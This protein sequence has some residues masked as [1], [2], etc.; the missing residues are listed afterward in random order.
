M[1]LTK[2]SVPTPS[3][4]VAPADYTAILAQLEAKNQA[5]TGRNPVDLDAE[6]IPEGTIILVGGVLYKAEAAEPITGTPSLYVKITPSGATASCAY[7]AN[8]S[9]VAWDAAEGG[10][11]DGSGN[12]HLFDEGLAVGTGVVG[13][14][15]TLLGQLH[16]SAM[17]GTLANARLAAMSAGTVKGQPIGGSGAPV[18]L[19][20][21]QLRLIFSDSLFSFGINSGAGGGAA[22][23]IDSDTYAVNEVRARIMMNSTTGDIS[24]K[25]PATGTYWFMF[26]EVGAG[27]L[28][29]RTGRSIAGGT[30]IVSVAPNTPTDNSVS[31]I[32]KRMT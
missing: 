31:L 9:G 8:L 6:E 26:M 19:R 24:Y 3:A 15:R 30:T 7:V 23:A 21:A 13:S 10:Y 2:V 12:L 29:T 17:Y 27:T 14:A 22:R 16:V 28:Y 25:L 1:S 32:I 5:Y 18:D 11:Y 4:P 20:A